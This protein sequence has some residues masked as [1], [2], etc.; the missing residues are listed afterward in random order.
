MKQGV[1]RKVISLVAVTI[2]SVGL[3]AGCE[4]RSNVPINPITGEGDILDFDLEAKICGAT[5]SESLI[6]FG[7]VKGQE[8]KT[9]RLCGVVD[10]GSPH[11]T[12]LA[13]HQINGLH[14]QN[15]KGQ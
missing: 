3:M 11:N 10:Y 2:M 13:A 8:E 14:L 6:V 1:L 5:A 12:Y 4:E 15:G 9:Y 7:Q